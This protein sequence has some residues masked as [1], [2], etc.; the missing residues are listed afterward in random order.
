LIIDLHPAWSGP[1]TA[2][3]PCFKNLQTAVIDEFEKRVDIILVDVEKLEELKNPAFEMN[4]TKP[5]IILAL[6]GKIVHEVNG[7]NNSEL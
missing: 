5:K 4:T 7:P 3:E 1:C 6:E 2:L